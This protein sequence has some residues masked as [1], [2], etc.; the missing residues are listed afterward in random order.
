MLSTRRSVLRKKGF[1]LTP[2]TPVS[3]RLPAELWEKCGWVAE[4]VGATRTE[5]VRNTL[6]NA[7]KCAQPPAN[8]KSRMILA[9]TKQWDSWEKIAQH[10]GVPLN[11]L[12]CRAV[13]RLV[14]VAKASGVD[15]DSDGNL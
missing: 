15:V 10:Y 5:F 12:I 13:N 4:A 14:P 7:T 8:A 9:P 3:L 1:K 6:H 2:L 11:E